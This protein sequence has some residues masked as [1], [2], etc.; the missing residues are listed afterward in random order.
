MPILKTIRTFAILFWLALFGQLPAHATSSLA[1]YNVAPN[2]V[3]VAGISS[4]GYM[5]VQLQVAYSASIYGTAVVAGGTYYCA[6]DNSILWAAAC[7]SGVGVPV[8]TLVN[9]TKAQATAG[10]IDPVSNIAGKPIYMFSGVLDTV[11]FQP[12]MDDLKQYYAAFTN[13]SEITYNRTTP[14][15]HSW[16][17]PDSLLPCAYLGAPFMNN[18]WFD[19]EHD[20]LTR[21]YGTLHARS[22]HTGGSYIQ[23]DQ[24]PFCAGSDCSKIAMDTTAWAY[25]PRNCASGQACKLTVALHGCLSNQETLGTTF[26]K[27]SGINEWADNNNIVVLYPQTIASVIPVNPEGCWDWWGYT[28]SN[29]AEKSSAQMTAI[30]AMVQR[31]T[32]GAH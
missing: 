3:T 9:Y 11:D 32:S 15:E 12:T 18:C 31:I 26:V 7:A 25:V 17:T 13:S 30:M 23:F 20:F 19:M 24:N 8:S 10:T 2:T 29:Y 16:V 22:A 27:S 6:Q 14:A 5:A 28:G 1:A 4:G 21:F